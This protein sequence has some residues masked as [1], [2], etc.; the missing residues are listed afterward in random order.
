MEWKAPEF[1]EIE[2]NAEIGAY[3]RDD[4]PACDLEAA[5]AMPGAT[6]TPQSIPDPPA[7]RG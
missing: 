3:Q 7:S 6:V 1:T 2:M 4:T 5:K